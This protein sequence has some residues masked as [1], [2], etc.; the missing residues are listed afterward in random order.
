LKFDDDE[1]EFLNTPQRKVAAKFVVSK[2][3][4]LSNL[5]KQW[6]KDRQAGLL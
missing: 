2:D 6:E 5:E 4:L 3:N 1:D